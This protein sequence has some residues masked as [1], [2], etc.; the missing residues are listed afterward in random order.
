[1]AKEYFSHDHYARNDRRISA[2]VKDFKSSGYGIFWC[3]VEMLHEDPNGIDYDDIT[4]CAIAKDLNEE[5]KFIRQVLD[6]CINNYKLFTITDGKFKSNR[7]NNNLDKRQNISEVRSSAGKA[8][9]ILKQ[10]ST[11]VQQNDTKERKGKEK[12]LKERKD[13]LIKPKIDFEI[14]LSDFEIGKAVEYLT[15]TKHAKVDTRTVQ[16]IWETFKIKNFTGEKSYS[17]ERDIIRHFFESLKFVQLNGQ[18]HQQ[19]SSIRT[20]SGGKSAGAEQLVGIL[21]AELDADAAR[22]KDG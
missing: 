14:L 17:G 11:N 16:T 12:K 6:G 1:M 18:S 20:S 3:V 13:I 4:I 15:I 9:A 19:T 2:L 10:V 22:A 21:K 5:E 8:S 7:V